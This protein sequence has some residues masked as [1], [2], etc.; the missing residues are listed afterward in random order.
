MME[1]AVEK[2]PF[3]GLGLTLR[4]LRQSKR[5]RQREV[6]ERAGVT[7]ASLSSYESGRQVPALHTL[8]KVLAALGEDVEGFGHGLKLVQD[9][10]ARGEAAPL[11]R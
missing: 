11:D 10:G 2:L 3:E 4:L 5:L 7:M 8:G 6:A 9:L 1:G